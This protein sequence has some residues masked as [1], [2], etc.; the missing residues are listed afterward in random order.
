MSSF[1][2]FRLRSLSLSVERDRDRFFRSFLSRFSF[3]PRDFERLRVLERRSLL[4]DLSLERS[5]ERR[6]GDL[7]LERD[8]S[9]ERGDF[10][11]REDMVYW[12]APLQSPPRKS[13]FFTDFVSKFFTFAH[14]S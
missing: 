1:L 6:R 12:G 2:C 13:F 3:L 4:R 9:R 10:R 5:R 11:S 14:E 7:L 8:R